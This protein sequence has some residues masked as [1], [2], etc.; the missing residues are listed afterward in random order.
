MTVIH[1]RIDV[2]VGQQAVGQQAQQLGRRRLDNHTS[3]NYA[4]PRV[5]CFLFLEI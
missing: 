4:L 1:D 2:V 3:M 5:R